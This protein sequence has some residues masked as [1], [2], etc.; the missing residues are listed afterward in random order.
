VWIKPYTED[1][2]DR[3]PKEG[4][5]HVQVLCPGFAVDCLE[6]LEEIAIRDCEQFILAGGESLEY[7]PALN[8]GAAHVG[9]LAAL[10]G[11]HLQGWT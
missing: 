6:T 5:H 1:L 10:I 4:I 2:L 9:A 7:I 11:R 8:A 3:W